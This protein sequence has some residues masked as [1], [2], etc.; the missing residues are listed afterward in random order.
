M[1][2]DHN[3]KHCGPFTFSRNGLSHF[4]F[5]IE[6]DDEYGAKINLFTPFFLLT[7]RTPRFMT[8]K[9]GHEYGIRITDTS[10]SII[11][12][13]CRWEDTGP[14]WLYPWR[15]LHT[16]RA[17]T[18]P[19]KRV[20]RIRDY[21]GE[22]IEATT[23]VEE[24]EVRHGPSSGPWRVVGW[25]RKNTIYRWMDIQFAS[26]VG[27]GK[28]SWKGGTLGHSIDIKQTESME[29]AMRRYCDNERL[30]FLGV[31]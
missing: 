14:S 22:V 16:V 1:L 11:R 9:L 21:D 5:S 28:G 25:L 27:S 19:T 4:L 6:N 31:V 20:F 30:E 18:Y 15:D 10:A 2:S 26:E 8:V 24:R 29:A 12:Q 17:D 23:H 13:T 3:D 7:C